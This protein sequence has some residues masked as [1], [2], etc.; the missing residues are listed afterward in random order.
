MSHTQSSLTWR[1]IKVV[2]VFRPVAQPGRVVV[3]VRPTRPRCRPW[4][5]EDIDSIARS[6][7]GDIMAEVGLPIAFGVLMGAILQQ[8]KRFSGW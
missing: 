5:R 7:F 6:G 3:G 1:R 8:T 2:V 4:R